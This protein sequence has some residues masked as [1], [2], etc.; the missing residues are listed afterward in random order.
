M[1]KKKYRNIHT[2]FDKAKRGELDVDTTTSRTRLFPQ[3]HYNE[4]A[5]V[6]KPYLHFIDERALGKA[7]DTFM[8]SE[9]N[10]TQIKD[11][12]KQF[13]KELISPDTLQAEMKRIYDKFPKSVIYDMYKMY[14]SDIKRLS[15]ENRNKTNKF[16]YQMLEKAADPVLKILTKENTIKSMIFTRGLVQYYV[17]MMAQIK[18]EDPEAFKEM[19][20]QLQGKGGSGKG[21]DNA[22]GEGQGGDESQ[23]GGGENQ[24]GSGKN[25]SGKGSA[26]G[27]SIQQQLEDLK[28]KF[29]NSAG[30]KKILNKIM[31]DAKQTSEKL[32]KIMSQEELDNLWKD[33]AGA[34]GYGNDSAEH[35]LDDHWLNQMTNE[36]KNVSM[37]LQGVKEKIKKLLD[38]SISYFSSREIVRY[39]NIFEADS[40]AG[41]ED[42]ELLHPQIRKIFMEDI[43]I[44]DIKR[45]GKIDIYIDISGSM[46]SSCG[47]GMS[48]IIFAKAFAYKMKELNMLNEVY[49]FN[50]SVKHAGNSVTSILALT[51]GG[52][53]DL[54]RVVTQIKQH[55]RNA[56]VLTDAEDQCY[57]YSEYAYFIGVKGAHFGTF[58]EDTLKEYYESSQLI[59]FDGDRT[60]AVNAHGGPNH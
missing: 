24:E 40:L 39:D 54:N 56:I 13:N 46:D 28:N 4:K 51:A 14:Y 16:R 1:A 11:L 27:K 20:D 31:D 29:E 41:L 43:N 21:S 52:G 17:M 55:G 34:N 44:K 33:L 36:L 9:R 18:Q 6:I 7:V 12:A 57:I 30:G 5:E 23:E 45:L 35:K 50:N 15:F 19:M 58:R 53:T 22:Q 10:H 42:Y 32:E 3:F 37:K 2:I 59:I 26:Q 38:K 60:Y 8:C 49:K 47:N 25:S 48:K